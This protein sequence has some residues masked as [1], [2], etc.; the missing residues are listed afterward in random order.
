MK[1]IIGKGINKQN[2]N[3]FGNNSNTATESELIANEFN[4]FFGSI[5]SSTI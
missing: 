5:L 2:K 1:S 3:S 4:E